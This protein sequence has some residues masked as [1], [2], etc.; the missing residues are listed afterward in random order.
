MASLHDASWALNTSFW[1]ASDKQVNVL[2]DLVV[3][4]IS[5]SLMA[6]IMHIISE[7]IEWL[8]L[9]LMN[10]PPWSLLLG[11]WFSLGLYRDRW[12]GINFKDFHG[13]PVLADHVF[14]HIIDMLLSYK[15]RVPRATVL[16]R[17]YGGIIVV[18]CVVLRIK[19][20]TS[21]RSVIAW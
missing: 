9:Y 6:I 7:S 5:M 14:A 21:M 18:E 2:L 10:L 17:A 20:A 11:A 4:S 16:F 1:Q 19:G 15:F 12:L 13:F 3:D 8:S